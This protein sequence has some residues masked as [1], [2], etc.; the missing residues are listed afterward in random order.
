M[1][2]LYQFTNVVIKSLT[3]FRRRNNIVKCNKVS[4]ELL[5]LL[6]YDAVGMPIVTGIKAQV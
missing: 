3:N 6:Y 4:P 5:Q 2:V 1:N